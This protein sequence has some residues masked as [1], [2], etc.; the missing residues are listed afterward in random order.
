MTPK[1]YFDGARILDGLA[2]FYHKK[3]NTNENSNDSLELIYNT[4]DE[5][6]KDIKNI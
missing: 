2:L 6:L 5:K 4:N 3:I 1:F